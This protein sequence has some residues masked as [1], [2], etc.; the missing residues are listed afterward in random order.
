MQNRLHL[1]IGLPDLG[2]EMALP[3]RVAPQLLAHEALQQKIADRLDRGVGK[4][5]L[6]KPAT[7]FYVELQVDQ[8]GSIGRAGDSGK[9]R[10]GLD[11]VDVEFDIGDRREGDLQ[12]AQHDLDHALDQLHLDGREGA[13][14][15]AGILAA[16]LAAEQQVERRIGQIR[17]DRDETGIL[18]G[19]GAEHRELHR[20]RNRVEII[21]EAH[22]TDVVE[23]NLDIVLK[24]V[25][26]AGRQEAHHP[27][28]DDL[29]HRQAF[30]GNDARIDDGADAAGTGCGEFVQR[31][32]EQL[33]DLVL[34]ENTV[35]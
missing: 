10:I 19:L 18:P 34:V 24:E 20:Q 4:E 9:A 26:Q 25:A 17:F 23:G 30:V 3:D 35:G 14:V 16:A 28:E 31:E 12:V 33:V 22:G 13:P 32:A 27:V 2:S 15:E 11:P 21:A 8:D 1:E 5:N 7:A 6:Q 29:Q